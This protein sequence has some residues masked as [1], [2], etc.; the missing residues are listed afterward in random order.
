MGT[1]QTGLDF[2]PTAIISYFF[3]IL[4]QGFSLQLEM[5]KYLAPKYVAVLS[6]FEKNY[7]Y[8]NS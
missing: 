3:W 4:G 1:G 7:L 2:S 6:I 8:Y 5:R